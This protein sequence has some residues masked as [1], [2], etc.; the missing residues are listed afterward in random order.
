MSAPPDSLPLWGQW[1]LSEES[2]LLTVLLVVAGAA[3]HL[4]N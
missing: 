4:L 1:R 2:G 3:L